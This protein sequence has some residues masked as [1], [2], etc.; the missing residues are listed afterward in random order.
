VGKAGPWQHSCWLWPSDTAS[1]FVGPNGLTLADTASGLCL[2]F[3]PA[4]PVKRGGFSLIT[5]SG[6]LGLFLWNLLEGEQVGLAKFASIGN[7]LNL[8]ECDFLEYLGTDPDTRVI[9]LYLESIG[10]GRR[11]IELAQR[12]DKTGDRLQGQHHFGRSAGGNEP[13][14]LP[15]Q[16]RGD[17]RRRL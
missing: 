17:H 4:F 13:H 2:P 14:R 6:G 11:L 5:Q 9:G 12:I 10:N 8:D 3:V 15:R 16:R 7:K 1:A